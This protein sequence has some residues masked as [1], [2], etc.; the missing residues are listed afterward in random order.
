MNSE[1][2]AYLWITAGV[3][4]AV[5]FPVLRA[6]VT[7]EF[8]TA[9]GPGLPPWVKRYLILFGFSLVTA[10]ICLAIWDSQNPTGTLAWYTAFL[11]GFG[12]E[13]AVEKFLRP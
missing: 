3:V 5:I 4:V 12:W 7:Q 2:Y 10:L 8:G 13:S 1:I 9:Q 6:L 11:L